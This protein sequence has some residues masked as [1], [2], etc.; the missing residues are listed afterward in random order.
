VRRDSGSCQNILRAAL[1]KS[2]AEV[3]AFEH[4]AFSNPHSARLDL[5]VSPLSGVAEGETPSG[6][7]VIHPSKPKPGTLGIPAGRPRYPVNRQYGA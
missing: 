6:Q 4:L 3:F 1:G 5:F 2:G 7:P